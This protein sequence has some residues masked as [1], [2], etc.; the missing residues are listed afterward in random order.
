MLSNIFSSD[1]RLKENVEFVGKNHKGFNIY[2][3]DWNNKA[4]QLGEFG[5]SVGVLAQELLKTHPERVIL[6][7]NGYYQVN[8]AGIWR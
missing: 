4:N 7:D 5:S 8:Y 6:H 2:K 3:W 1:V